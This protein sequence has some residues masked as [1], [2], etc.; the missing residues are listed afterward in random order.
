[1]NN[2]LKVKDNPGLIRDTSSNAILACDL[3]EKTKFMQQQ[4]RERAILNFENLESKVENLQS[5]VNS[6]K[7]MLQQLINK[8][9]K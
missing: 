6:I 4:K 2:F 8:N 9:S 7:D 1:M 5:D 3:E